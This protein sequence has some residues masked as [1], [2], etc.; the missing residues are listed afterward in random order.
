MAFRGLP[1][2]RL[3]A[4]ST[5]L[6]PMKLDFNSGLT[7][8]GTMAIAQSPMRNGQGTMFQSSGKGLAASEA[9]M[10]ALGAMAAPGTFLSAPGAMMAAP[11]QLPLQAFQESMVRNLLSIGTAKQGPPLVEARDRELLQGGNPGLGNL[12]GGQ[13]LL[14]KEHQVNQSLNDWYL[15]MKPNWDGLKGSM[16]LL[17]EDL[18]H[19]LSKQETRQTVKLK[20]TPTL[21]DVIN[22]Y[23]RFPSRDDWIQRPFY[24]FFGLLLSI[25]DNVRLI[26]SN[27]QALKHFDFQEQLKRLGDL[28]E[29]D[30]PQHEIHSDVSKITKDLEL[31]DQMKRYIPL[32]SIVPIALDNVNQIQEIL[33][34]AVSPLETRNVAR[35]NLPVHDVPIML[36]T[37][38]VPAPM[39]VNQT[40]A[41]VISMYRNL[42]RGLEEE[43]KLSRT[44]LGRAYLYIDQLNHNNQIVLDQYI[45][46]KTQGTALQ[47]MLQIFRV[48]VSGMKMKDVSDFNF[49][50]STFAAGIFDH[51]GGNLTIKDADVNLFIPEGAIPR[52]TRKE[53][54]MYLDQDEHLKLEKQSETRVAPIIHCGPPGTTFDVPFVLTF[55]H[56]AENKDHWTFSG[57]IKDSSNADSDWEPIDDTEGISFVYEDHCIVMVKHFTRYTMTGVAETEGTKR[58]NICSFG[59]EYNGGNTYTFKV[60]AFNPYDKEAVIKYQIEN[61]EERR[62]DVQIIR[63]Q[64]TGE[65]V[66]VNLNEIKEGW[67]SEYKP[68][69]TLKYEELWYEKNEDGC[70]LPAGCRFRLKNTDSNNHDSVYCRMKVKQNGNTEEKYLHMDAQRII[71][72]YQMVPPPAPADSDL[73]LQMSRRIAGTQHEFYKKLPEKV[74]HHLMTTLDI[75]R[76]GK[77]GPL[78]WRALADGMGINSGIIEKMKKCMKDQTL[79]L[80]KVLDKKYKTAE[81]FCN[82]L[83]EIFRNAE[84]LRE[85]EWVLPYTSHVASGSI[86]N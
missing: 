69:M 49:S 15:K 58:M 25:K 19:L 21:E 26:I 24:Q 43:I 30:R 63:V 34:N 72:G 64:N 44:E 56:C 36:Q 62:D 50:T 78:D 7:E 67:K 20:E 51:N 8:Q 73:N 77:S 3:D 57:K 76:E 16:N 82:T 17:I 70:D 10:A 6:V 4:S 33:E 83:Y 18:D 74:C 85:A 23:E 45:P 81:E 11:G 65:D 75:E 29:G 42:S 9:M 47:K 1:H 79:N 80:L 39:S 37:Q 13:V 52:G 5:G 59:K 53:V 55:P 2:T 14:G 35:S 38:A 27:V 40:D 12:T 32:I 60:R 22:A 46:E 31:S 71:A 48:N 61:K 68:E 84:L 28:V 66:E 54:Y 41:Q 86:E